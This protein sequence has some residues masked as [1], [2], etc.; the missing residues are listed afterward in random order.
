V[1]LIPDIFVP[2]RAVWRFTVIP[3]SASQYRLYDAA[4]V[5][6]FHAIAFWPSPGVTVRP[7]GAE[8]VA[9]CVLVFAEPHA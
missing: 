4:P 7:S 8:S 2:T 5:T 3:A 6:R 1:A 9:T